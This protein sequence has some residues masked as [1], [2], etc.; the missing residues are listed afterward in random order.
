MDTLRGGPSGVCT[1]RKICVFCASV[2]VLNG[3][4]GGE[5]GVYLP[6]LQREGLQSPEVAGR[7]VLF[8]PLPKS[9]L[10]GCKVLLTLGLR[11]TGEAR[12]LSASFL[13]RDCQLEPSRRAGSLAWIDMALE[14]TLALTPIKQLQHTDPL[15]SPIV[16]N[17]GGE[18]T[19]CLVILKF[20]GIICLSL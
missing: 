4:P 11:F 20:P 15:Y 8:I 16:L 12:R 19:G 13:E 18:S 14:P 10:C 6:E 7:R 1:Y 9:S 3:F 5:C 17:A 2:T